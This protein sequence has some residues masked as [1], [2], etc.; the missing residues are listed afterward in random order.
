MCAS[1]YWY[2]YSRV[3]T[4]RG[5]YSL[6]YKAASVATILALALAL[7]AVHVGSACDIAAVERGGRGAESS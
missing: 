5:K 6:E 3:Y 1:R 7:A 2:M 4:P